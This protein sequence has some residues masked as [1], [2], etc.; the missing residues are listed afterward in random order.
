MLAE[1]SRLW[2]TG[3]A[4][5]LAVQITPVSSG[6]LPDSSFRACLKR[7]AIP[8]QQC[9]VCLQVL[10]LAALISFA[11]AYL[12]EGS[13]EEGIRAYIE[14]FVILL[15]LVLNAIVGVWQ[16]ANA[17]KALEALMEMQSV[18]AKVV[19]DRKLVSWGSVFSSTGVLATQQSSSREQHT[20]K[21]PYGRRPSLV[22]PVECRSLSLRC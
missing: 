19:R 9:T 18:T 16:E 4:A 7:A 3:L 13:H 8:A 17:E 10:L 21:S 22:K 15:I 2:A 11:L 1:P 5:F 20:V 6:A 12:D 14:P